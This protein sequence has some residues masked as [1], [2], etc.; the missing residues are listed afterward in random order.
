MWLLRETDVTAHLVDESIKGDWNFFKGECIYMTYMLLG[1]LKDK[2]DTRD[3]KV[4]V[5]REKHLL[6]GDLD[7]CHSGAD[8]VSHCV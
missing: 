7:I 2:F 4:N 5:K 3:R 1:K 6:N 8:K